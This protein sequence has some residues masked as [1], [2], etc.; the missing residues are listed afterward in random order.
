MH[1]VDNNSHSAANIL[2]VRH[3]FLCPNVLVDCLILDHKCHSIVDV[4]FFFQI[5]T[6]FMNPTV[7]FL[8]MT[9]NETLCSNFSVSDCFIGCQQYLLLN[10]YAQNAH[11]VLT[12]NFKHKEF[13]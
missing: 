7:M 2:H 9:T 3:P 10:M 13:L 12:S 5:V 4:V 11:N 1:G 6:S 8:A